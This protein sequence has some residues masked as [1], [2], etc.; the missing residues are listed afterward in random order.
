[1]TDV[2][3]RAGRAARALQAD[4]GQVQGLHRDP[5]GQRLPVAAHDAVRPVRHA[6]RVPDPHRRRCTASPRRASPRTGCTRATTSRPR[7]AQRETPPVAAGLLEIQSRDA[8]LER[9]PRAHQG[10][11]LPRRGLRVHAEGQD[12]GA[13]ARRDRRSTSPTRV[14][15]D[16]GN[17]CVAARINYELG[18]AAH[19]AA[20]TATTSRSSRADRAPESVV[21]VVRRHRQGA[22]AHPPLPEG[23]AAEGVGGARRA[24]A[25]TRR[26]RRSRSSRT[27]SRGTAGKRCQGIRRQEP[28]RHPRRHRARQ[29]AV[30]R[31]RAGADAS[32]RARP[33]DAG[34]QPA[35][36]KPAR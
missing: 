19:R 18:A 8:R 1:M 23:H 26:W 20:R 7:R 11:P 36:S 33:D 4:P 10:R 13:A 3:R 32:R 31:R 6:G 30:V 5:Q 28:A 15:T 24:A 2:L 25:R 9:V 12:H 16:I 35:P 22:L 27:R 14:H 29:A 34:T 21:A 17:H